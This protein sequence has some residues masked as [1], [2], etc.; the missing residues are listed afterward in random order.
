MGYLPCLV[1]KDRNSDK[2]VQVTPRKNA[3]FLSSL[4]ERDAKMTRMVM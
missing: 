2:F 3:I 4:V 1:E